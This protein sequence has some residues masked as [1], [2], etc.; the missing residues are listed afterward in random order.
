MESLVI[1]SK[2]EGLWPAKVLISDLK[3]PMAMCLA[4]VFK[5][6]LQILPTEF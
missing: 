2:G 5:V 3:E 6:S 1:I 4:K